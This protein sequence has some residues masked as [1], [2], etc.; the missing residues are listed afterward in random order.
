ML[1][2]KKLNKIKKHKE[3][4]IQSSPY[5]FNIKPLQINNHFDYKYYNEFYG[6]E[7]IVL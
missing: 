4:I 6:F 7:F 3:I 2:S 5:D 1:I